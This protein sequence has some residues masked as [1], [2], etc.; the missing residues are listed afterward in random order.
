MIIPEDQKEIKNKFR[1][2]KIISI[3]CATTPIVLVLVAY[4]LSM[5]GPF[6]GLN[7]GSDPQFLFTVRVVLICLG[8]LHPL[9]AYLLNKYLFNIDKILEKLSSVENIKKE[10]QESINSPHISSEQKTEWQ[11]WIKNPQ[12]QELLRKIRRNL[13][14]DNL[15]SSKII[16][17]ALGEGPSIM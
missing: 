16:V 4:S 13:F 17:L 9:A 12:E 15:I 7:K 8:L 6:A 10:I 3:F 11:E 14:L 1:P 2:Y 5:D